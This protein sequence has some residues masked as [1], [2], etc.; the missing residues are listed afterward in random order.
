MYIMLFR[1][2][3][4]PC[5]RAPCSMGLVLTTFQRLT[6]QLEDLEVPFTED[7]PGA[8]NS[9]DHIVDAVFGSFTCPGS[10]GHRITLIARRFQF[11]R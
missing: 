7:F 3:L 2:V 10:R 8:I 1:I 6:K 11:L 4:I 5:S 9:T